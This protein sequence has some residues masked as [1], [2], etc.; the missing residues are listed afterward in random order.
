VTMSATHDGVGGRRTGALMVLEDVT[1]RRRA[2]EDLR[3]WEARYRRLFEQIPIG[4]FQCG[5][6]GRLL[7]VNRAFLGVLG[8]D[9]VDAV[10]GSGIADFVADLETRST[11]QDALAGGG[12]VHEMH[13]TLQRKDG[14]RVPAI[15]DVRP[16]RSADGSV[17]YLD[18]TLREM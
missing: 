4:L 16:V 7:S 1:R 9:S 3:A 5:M 12:R 13:V 15:L 2:E 17:E 8:L 10:R 14:E 11:I 6:E 18:G